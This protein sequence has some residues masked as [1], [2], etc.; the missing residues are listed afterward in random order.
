[1]RVWR[2]QNLPHPFGP[3]RPPLDTCHPPW[4][5]HPQNL[6]C[7][8]L[9]PAQWWSNSYMRPLGVR[10]APKVHL[11]AVLDL[12]RWLC[13]PRLALSLSAKLPPPRSLAG[14][15]SSKAF[16]SLT[17]EQTCPK[18]CV[19]IVNHRYP[20]PC[21]LALRKKIWCSVQAPETSS[22]LPQPARLGAGRDQC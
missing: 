8:A 15:L 11:R 17:R 22:P 2:S 13:S 21:T 3:S 12:I 4:R 10:S 16:S 1:M 18:F 14:N 6:T 9:E 7:S 5:R 19:L 20:L